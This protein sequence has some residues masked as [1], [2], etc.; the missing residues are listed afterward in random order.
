MKLVIL[1]FNILVCGIGFSQT[2]A[3]DFGSMNYS[4]I[5]VKNNISKIKKTRTRSDIDSTLLNWVEDYKFNDLGEVVLQVII[6]NLGDTVSITSIDYHKNGLKSVTR[7]GKSLNRLDTIIKSKVDFEKKV[8]YKKEILKEENVEYNECIW[9][10]KFWRPIKVIKS[11]SNGYEKT[12][13]QNSSMYDTVLYSY[14][15]KP[16]LKVVHRYLNDTSNLSFIDSFFYEN[17]NLIEHKRFY[18]I[19]FVIKD[20]KYKY[21]KE[22][23]L[24]SIENISRDGKIEKNQFI[25]EN[26]V[27]KENRV[28]TTHLDFPEVKYLIINDWL[29]E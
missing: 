24:L 14:V 19:Q 4:E 18:E 8:V 10:D 7:K 11:Y 2:H 27:I 20:L 5:I 16:N 12:T 17:S 28:I 22:G 9:Y 25:Y 13:L 21:D 3:L 26:G 29:Y 6:D 15:E 1:I 23:L